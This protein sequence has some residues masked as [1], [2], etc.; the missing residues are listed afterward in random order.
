MTIFYF[1][2]ANVG[3]WPYPGQINFCVETISFHQQFNALEVLR[4]LRKPITVDV[5][6][7]IP[8]HINDFLLWRLCADSLREILHSQCRCISG[9][10]VSC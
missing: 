2:L 5:R 4:Q 6:F 1:Q 7:L 10:V 9:L 3:K 8:S